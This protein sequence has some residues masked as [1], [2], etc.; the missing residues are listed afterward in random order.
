ME[1]KISVI[2]PVYNVENYLERAIES[3]E[4]QTIGFNDLEVILVN[5]GSTD[6]SSKIIDYYSKRYDNVVAV[7]YTES[8]G[9]AGKPRNEGLK[10]ASAEY[11]MF[12]DPDDYFT[13]DACE[14]LYN[15]I[16]HNKSD[17]A[18]G[19]Y[20][21]I[22]EDGTSIVYPSVIPDD[23]P[24]KVANTNI[25]DSAFL[26]KLAPSVWTKIF[27]KSFIINNNI[28]FPEGIVAQDLVFVI[29]SLFSAQNITFLKKIIYNYRLRK[30]SNKS[31]S[32]IHDKKYFLGLNES[33]KMVFE[34]FKLFDKMSYY[35]IIL[36]GF[37]NYK[38]QDIFYSEKLIDESKMD[39]LRNFNWLFVE[40][41]KY[42][43]K[44]SDKMNEI[45]FN[46]ILIGELDNA[47]AIHNKY[48]CIKS[49]YI[50]EISKVESGKIWL[51]MKLEQERNA[52]LELKTWVEELEKGREWMKGQISLHSKELA[53]Q[54]DIIEE[55][56]KWNDELKNAN[57]WLK[58]QVDNYQKECVNQ[59]KIIEEL[60]EWISILEKE[61]G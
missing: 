44:P 55:L 26:L 11:V 41:E 13:N 19:T 58:T 42:K 9:A 51:E 53:E 54:K 28:T 47:I 50:D 56:Q 33:H 39:V 60:R 10:L 20:R 16:T 22:S 21:C 36:E 43:I 52:V 40:C 48:G 59:K 57:D 49:D 17:V 5:D 46:S 18:F 12:L 29:H 37:L 6:N 7:H 32:Y 25:D 34:L 27:R 4:N 23:F 35:S 38:F 31:I 1:Y 8:S 3:L 2:V 61:K 30:N 24:D 45:L 15:S 14:V